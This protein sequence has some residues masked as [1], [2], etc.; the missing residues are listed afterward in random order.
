MI[1]DKTRQFMARLAQLCDEFDAEIE[2]DGTIEVTGE[3][4]AVCRFNYIWACGK[5]TYLERAKPHYFAQEVDRRGQTV[6][7]D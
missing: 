3:S 2:A 7:L 4:G 6:D 1:D 5:S